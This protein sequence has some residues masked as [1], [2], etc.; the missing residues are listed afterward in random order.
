VPGPL[1]YVERLVNGAVNIEQEVNAQAAQVV[2]HLEALPAGAADIVV[3][4]ELVHGILHVWQLPAAA[5]DALN[6]I[7]AEVVAAEVVAV[8]GG[9][10][11]HRGL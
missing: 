7:G 6:V 4:D 5:A 9:E 10:I 2:E 8:G 3:Q 11:F 1:L